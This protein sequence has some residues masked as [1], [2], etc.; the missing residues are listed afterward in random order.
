MT[1][2]QKADRRQLEAFQQVLCSRGNQEE[3]ALDLWF[4]HMLN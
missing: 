1:S 2:R 3:D 4:H